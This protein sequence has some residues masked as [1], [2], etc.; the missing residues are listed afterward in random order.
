MRRILLAAATATSLVASPFLASAATLTPGDLARVVKL[1]DPQIAPDGHTVAVVEQR[2]DLTDDEFR[3]E[4]VLVDVAGHA[5]RPLT[6]DRHH[7]G[8]PRWSPSGDRLAFTAPDEHGHLQLYVLPM[9]GG[10]ALAVTHV[11]DGIDQFAWSPDG[12]TFAIAAIDPAPDRRGEDKYRTAFSVG[13]DDF[14][15]REKPRSSHVWLVPATGGDPRRLTSGTWSLP[16]SLPPGP[17]SSPLQFSPDGKS[18]ALV[19]QATPSTGDEPQTRIQVLDIATGHR[20]DLTGQGLLEGFPRISPDGGIVAYWRNR[21][22]KAWQFQDVLLAPFAGGPGHD[23]TTALDKNIYGTWW[24]PDGRSLLVGASQ[25]TTVGLWLQPLDGG[26]ATRLDLGA[27]MPTNT[28]WIDADVG[29]DGRIAFIGQTRTDPYELYLTTPGAHPQ[30]LT[31]ENRSLASA[32][33]GRTQTVTWTGPAGGSSPGG[34]T[35][36][37]LDGVL[38]YPPGTKPG[39]ALPLVLVI[40]GG[41]NYASRDHFNLFSQILA[42]HGWLVFEPNYRGSDNEDNAFFAAIYDDAGQGPGEDVMAGVKSLID[43]GLAD[44]SHMAVSGW[45]Y[46]GF[47]TT[48]LLGHDPV[49]QAAVAGAAV[50]DWVDMYDLS[51]GNVTTTAQ[52]SGSPWVA[53]GRAHYERQSPDTAFPRVR[54]PTLVLCDVGDYRVPITQSYGLYRALRDNHVETEFYA[55]P[56]GGHFPSDPIRQIDVDQ[57]WV[58]WLASHMNANAIATH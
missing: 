54:T 46:G 57:R 58:G 22:G 32:T 17:P 27:V 52:V 38:T 45:S 40:H 42:S 55:Y 13:D 19:L 11:K 26:S 9:A 2:A 30:V 14:T 8:S 7:A 18:I 41:P 49:W 44:R 24:M 15:T 20:R 36:R 33:L 39:H 25:A 34:G 1:S 21:D 29:R 4:I 23:V 3:T 48:W 56:V 35:G 16:V 50:T 10:D 5:V 53:G 6:R 31:N 28:F 47:M 51:D 37:Q 12:R 43:R